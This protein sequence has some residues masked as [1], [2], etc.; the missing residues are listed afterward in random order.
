MPSGVRR[1][2]DAWHRAECAIAVLAFAAIAALLIA[3]VLGREL[4]APLLRG[5]GADVGAGGIF[6]AQKVAIY[7]L[8]VGTYLG[9]GIA[10]VAGTHLVPRAGFGWIPSRWGPAMDRVADVLTGLVLLVAGGYGVHLVQ[11]SFVA[12]VRMPSLGWSL[13]PVQ[14]VVPLGLWSAAL[15]YLA[16]AA[17]PGLRPKPPEIVE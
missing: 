2:F 10:T 17:W 14:L 7:L 15:R 16:F 11:A 5:V 6:G 3:D 13:W 9:V 8:V 4:L 12:D 1:V